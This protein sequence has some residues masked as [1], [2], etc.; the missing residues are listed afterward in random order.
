MAFIIKEK[1][2]KVCAVVTFEFL[3]QHT[4]VDDWDDTLYQ[5]FAWCN[6]VEK[7]YPSMQLLLMTKAHVFYKPYQEHQINI[8]HNHFEQPKIDDTKQIILVSNV[9]DD[10]VTDM[11]ENELIAI[12]NSQSVNYEVLPAQ[13][14]TVVDFYTSNIIIKI[15]I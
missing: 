4:D 7:K 3:K 1:L 13:S 15:A 5:I 11:I 14:F 10:T 12:L 8:Y 6:E 2:G 9:S